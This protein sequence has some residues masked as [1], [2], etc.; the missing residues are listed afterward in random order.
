MRLRKERVS[1]QQKWI[2]EEEAQLAW[3]EY[4]RSEYKSSESHAKEA[5]RFDP[6]NASHARLLALLYVRRSELALAK[7]L[8]ELAIET[9]K[10]AMGPDHPSLA[11]DLNNLA[12]L[13][14]RQGEYSRARP[15][16]ERALRIDEAA[17]GPQPPRRRPR[18]QQPR[19]ATR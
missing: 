9:N 4:L 3:V 12:L 1:K 5:A 17:L 13:Y 8:F 15:L 19:D 11:V 14:V 18:P 7:P 16:H 6:T 10:A 2:A